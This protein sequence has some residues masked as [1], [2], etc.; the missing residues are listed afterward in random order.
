MPSALEN[1]PH[2]LTTAG[3][4]TVPQVPPHP[5]RPARRVTRV[6]RLTGGRRPCNS[7]GG[8]HSAGVAFCPLQNRNSGGQTPIKAR[9]TQEESYF[10]QMMGGFGALDEVP[11]H[12]GWLIFNTQAG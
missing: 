8:Q 1:L 5:R 2:C 7:P 12:S 3:L 10:W 4:S 11:I 6:Q 9:A